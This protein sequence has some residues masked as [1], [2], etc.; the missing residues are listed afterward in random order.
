MTADERATHERNWKVKIPHREDVLLSSIS[1]FNDYLAVNER[2]NG[3]N[4]FRIINLKN[5]SEQFVPFAEEV[6][7][8]S[9][10]TNAEPSLKTLR[11]NYSSLT[12]PNSVY[13]FNMETREVKLLKQTEILGGFDKNNYETKRLWATARDGTQVPI[14]IVYRKGFVQDGKSRMLLQAYGAYGNSTEPSF[15]HEILSLLDRGF[16]FAI[17]HVRGGSELGRAWYEDGKLLNKKNTFF[18]FIDC[19]RFLIDNKYTSPSSLFAI[20]TS[21][22]GLLMGAVANMA[23]ELFNGIIARVPFVDVITTML[24]ATIPLTSFEWDEWGNPAIEEYYHYMLSYSPYDQVS[25]QNYPNML[26]TTGYWDSQVQYWE[27]AKWVAK[28][29]AYKTDNNK[30]LLDTDMEVGHGGASGRFERLR[31][32]ALQYA[33]ILSL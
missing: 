5:G 33:F 21:A 10:S 26:V 8:A 29:R 14:S 31:G 6:Y 1:L 2:T 19:A 22:G 15:R 9:F 11:Y 12:T 18:D 24:D 23:P 16:V 17:A 30:L 3:L 7:T 20:G 32:I 4:Q 28:L 27:P 13:E 25:A